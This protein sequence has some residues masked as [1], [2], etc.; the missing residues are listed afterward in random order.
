MGEDKQPTGF[1]TEDVKIVRSLL[2]K[3]VV[4]ATYEDAMH[5]G[6]LQKSVAIEELRAILSS[7]DR[8]IER[9]LGS[10]NDGGEGEVR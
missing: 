8:G 10:N 3:H 7:Y 6:V 1:A 5:R 4:V 2:S 9:M